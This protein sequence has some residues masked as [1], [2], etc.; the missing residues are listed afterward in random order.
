MRLEAGMNLCSDKEL[1]YQPAQTVGFAV[2]SISVKDKNGF[3]V[4][5]L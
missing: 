4:D 2:D 3:M 1:K 5:Q